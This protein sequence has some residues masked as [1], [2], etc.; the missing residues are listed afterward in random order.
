MSLIG[1]PIGFYGY[2][3]PGNINLMVLELYNSKRHRFLMLMLALVI[4]FESIYC[5]VSLMFINNIKS[6]ARFFS[7]VESASYI[8]ILIMGLWMLF[9]KRTTNNKPHQNT[10]FRGVL[11]M[12]IHPQQI[13]YWLI[14]GSVLSGTLNLI[15]NNWTVVT[16]AFFNAVGTLL[17]MVAYMF[18]GKKI[19]DY[20]KL[21]IFHI[22]KAMGVLYILLFL[23][24]LFLE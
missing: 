22:N 7:F 4:I 1:I 13:P 9:E 10:I 5:I 12:I 3:F 6:N 19:L 21:N 24:H 11:N 2:V 23:S 15:P 18:F 8:L 16:F 17:A 20:F 14:A